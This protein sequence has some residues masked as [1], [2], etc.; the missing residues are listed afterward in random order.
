[1]KQLYIKQKVFSLSGKFTVK[2]EQEKD[3]YYVEGSFM[4]IPKTFSILNTT[5]DEVALITKKV[6]SFLPKFFVEVNGREVL[7]IKKELSF[8][9]ARYTIDS[10]GIEVHGNWWDMDFQVFQHGE[11]VGKVSKEW[12]TWGDSYKVQIL[13][14]EMEAIMIALVVAI[15]CV[16]ADD[17]AASSAATT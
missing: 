5:R 16:K 1:M 8:F 12:F 11:L 6:F 7:T 4:Q 14:E 15:D 17:A 2:D 10:A 13:N 9:K 3:V